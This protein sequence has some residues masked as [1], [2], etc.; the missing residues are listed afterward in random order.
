VPPK[1]QPVLRLTTR[2]AEGEREATGCTRRST[3]PASSSTASPP[4]SLGRAM[5]D[6][7]VAGTRNNQYK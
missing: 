3:T 6:A 4:T 7:L 1:P 2:V 5:L